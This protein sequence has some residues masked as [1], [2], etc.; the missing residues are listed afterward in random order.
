MKR[1]WSKSTPFM[2]LVLTSLLF[3]ASCGMP[4]YINLDGDVFITGSTPD[5]G[6]TIN[7]SLEVSSSAASKLMD[8]FPSGEGPSIKLFYI[9]SSQP[10]I[11]TSPITNN[12]NDASFKLSLADDYFNT[13]YR[14]TQGNGRPWSPETSSGTDSLAP[15]YYLYSDSSNSREY[16]VFRPDDDNLNTTPSGF[17]LGTFAQSIAISDQRASFIFG[18]SPEMDI[19]IKPD[20]F[21]SGFDFTVSKNAI[22]PGPGSDFPIG[23]KSSYLLEISTNETVPRIF[24]FTNYRKHPFPNIAK[25]SKDDLSRQYISNEDN[26]FYNNLVEDYSLNTNLYV[27]IFGAI[28]AG[29]GD[30]TN[31]YWSKLEYLGYI[32]L[33]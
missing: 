27:H 14:T 23:D 13:I 19:P 32:L 5:D 22:T 24:Y 10:N 8:Y 11:L 3:F 28:F 18:T 17:V 25:W 29:E 20:N 26:Y 7:V 31:I 1:C 15:G 21:T 12:A 6:Q 30:F 16:S 4:T 33:D 2:V 9:I